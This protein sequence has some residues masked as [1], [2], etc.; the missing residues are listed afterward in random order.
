LTNAHS[1]DFA[2]LVKVRRRG[3][4]VKYVA[5][6]LAV[7]TECD[8]AL[9]AVD[10]PGFWQGLAPV[11]WG[12]L[13]RLQTPVTVVGFPI[14]GDGMCITSG[15]VSRIEVREGGGGGRGMNDQPIFCLIEVGRGGKKVETFSTWAIDT[16]S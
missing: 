1:V 3:D 5:R 6:V 13:P 8:V 9:L 12:A 15:V 16:F 11:S 4:D 14:G 7:G 2:T 10:D